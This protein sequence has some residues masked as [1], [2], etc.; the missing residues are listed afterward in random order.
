[1]PEDHSIHRNDRRENAKSQI[2]RGLTMIAS[3]LI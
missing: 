3:L 2:N 1:M